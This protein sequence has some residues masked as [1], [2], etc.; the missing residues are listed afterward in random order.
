MLLPVLQTCRQLRRIA[1]FHKLLWRTTCTAAR[2]QFPAPKSQRHDVPL[3]AILD[4][5]DGVGLLGD[6]D[7]QDAS[8]IQ[9][10]HILNL[11]SLRMR[12]D[13]AHLRRYSHTDLPLLEVL[14]V[15]QVL[16][17][18]RERS[19]LSL[20]KSPKLHFLSL[21]S[22]SFVPTEA[23]PNLTHLALSD[24]YTQEYHLETANLLSRCP[25]LESL[26][27]SYPHKGQDIPI[28]PRPLQ[29][30]TLDRLRRV[31]LKL[32]SFSAPVT[33]FY[34]SLL[35]LNT[36]LAQAAIALQIQHKDVQDLS[37]HLGTLLLHA[38]KAKATDLSLSMS[39]VPGRGDIMYLS[40]TAV[41]SQGA[42]HISS[43]PFRAGIS[44]K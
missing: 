24:I 21:W 29:P 20:D 12:D 26:V 14:S 16:T 39:P 38:T 35:P 43:E 17:I 6:L 28:P 34:I 15:S 19:P 37:V 41:G 18:D 22:V 10:L 42:F 31:A 8:R 40:I 3:I 27:I 11:R 4:G 36:G 5:T 30:L 7:E 1:T 32:P 13:V 33:E 25:K 44:V 2:Y 9:E 23:F